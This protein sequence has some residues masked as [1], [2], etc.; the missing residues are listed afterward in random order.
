MMY[1]YRLYE[2]HDLKLSGLVKLAHNVANIFFFRRSVDCRHQKDRKEL[3]AVVS[4][5]DFEL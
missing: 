1:G 2:I 5:V 4:Q 3:N